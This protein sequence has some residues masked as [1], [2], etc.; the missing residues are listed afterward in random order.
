MS[1]KEQFE[2]K[3]ETS[4]NNLKTSIS[5]EKLTRLEIEKR[6]EK[7]LEIE[8][9]EIQII[10]QL[11][12]LEGLSI[13]EISIVTN[14]AEYEVYAYLDY[15]IS[16]INSVIRREIKELENTEANTLEKTSITSTHI[17]DIKG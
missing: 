3:L 4:F 2:K 14:R 13:S 8:N 7:V 5:G 15:I 1:T 9:H 17:L 16:R 6:I 10:T 11:K 12:Y